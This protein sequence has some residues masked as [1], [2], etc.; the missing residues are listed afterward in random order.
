MGI[1]P[2]RAGKTSVLVEADTLAWDHPRSCGK[3]QVIHNG[4]H[5]LSGSPPLVRERH[6]Q[7]GPGSEQAGI[8]PARAGKTVDDFL[9]VRMVEDHPR[10]CGKDTTPSREI[11][12]IS[13]SPPLVRE[14]PASSKMMIS[15]VGITPARAGKTHRLSCRLRSWW[16]HPRS[17]GKDGSEKSYAGAGLG[18][19]PLVRE[20]LRRTASASR[21]TRI[22]PARAG[23]T[24]MDPFI[25]AISLL[26][27]F[28][29]YLISLQDICPP[30]NI[31]H[32]SSKYS[33]HNPLFKEASHYVY[34]IIKSVL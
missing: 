17:C 34:S 6:V 16:D 26:P 29:I 32:V 27:V 19:P 24:V 1:T 9:R 2:A 18:S 3:D 20:R 28:K 15:F 7:G 30:K 33:Y 8:T 31:K 14:R 22:T 21:E 12:G 25:C 11:C 13:G 4:L 5:R 23:K 10:S